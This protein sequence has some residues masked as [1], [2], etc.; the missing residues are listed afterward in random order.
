MLGPDK[1]RQNVVLS[2]ALK[3]V[4]VELSRQDNRSLSNMM[5]H[6]LREWVSRQIGFERYRH[7][8]TGRIRP[9]GEM[10]PNMDAEAGGFNSPRNRTAER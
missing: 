5:E 6:V 8:E 4:L 10:R 7:L 3:S 2:K 9:P 1:V